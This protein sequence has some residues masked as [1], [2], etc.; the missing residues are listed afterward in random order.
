MAWSHWFDL[1]P[2]EV[3]NE[4]PT[5]RGVF[6]VARARDPHAYPLVPSLTVFIGAAADGQRGLR[7]VLAEIAAAS[8]GALHAERHEHG[9]LRFCFQGNLGADCARLHGAVLAD[10]AR[11]HGAP[12]RCNPEHA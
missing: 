4:A 12:P 2:N 3:A 1:T 8:S 10:F 7:A 9:G 6:C 11:G 5:S